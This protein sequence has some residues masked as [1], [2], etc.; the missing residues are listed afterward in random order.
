MRLATIRTVIIASGRGS[1]MRRL[2]FLIISVLVSALFLWLAVRD[3]PL[4]QVMNSIRQANLAWV[5]ACLVAI[6]AGIGTR[7]IRWRGLVDF[8]IPLLDSFYIVSVSFLLNQLPLRAGE[9]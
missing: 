9:V 7:A 5:F 3:V 1:F 8:K 2:V 6:T 4:D